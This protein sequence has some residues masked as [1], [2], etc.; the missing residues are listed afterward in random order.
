MAAYGTDEGLQSWLSSQG[1]SLPV[2]AT[3]ATL[4]EIG[5][6]Y[7]DAAYEVML[8][9]SHRAGGFEQELAWPRAG[10]R[11]N[12]QPVP[13]DLIPPAWVNASYRAAWLEANSPGWATGSTDPNRIT[14][15]EKV[16]VIEREFMTAAD[17]GG[18]ASAA[19]IAA[20]A[21]INGMVL[22]WLCSQGR[23]LNSLFRVI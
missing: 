2:G 15:R 7:V 21:L 19:G 10:H 22:P 12:G 1:L 13:E 8:Q 20:D 5:S 18:A 16:D 17:A 9:C 3:P 4:R 14:K 11:V 6:A 23:D